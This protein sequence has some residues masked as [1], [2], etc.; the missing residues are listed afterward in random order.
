[1][2]TDAHNSTVL[3]TGGAGFIG[4]AVIRHLLDATS[5]K[6]VNLDA[7]TYAADPDSLSIYSGNARYKF[8]KGDISDRETVARMF[9]EYRPE[10]VIH[11]AAESHVDRSIDDGSTFISTNIVGTYTLLEIARAYW[12]ELTEDRKSEFRF[13]HVSTDEV[14]GSLGTEGY[15]SEKSPYRPNSPYSASKA[16]SDHIARAWYKTYGFPVL[17]SNCSNNFGPS[18]FPEILI[19]LTIINAIQG[20]SIPVY[21]N[22]LNVRDWIYVDDHARALATIIFGG[23]TGE[24]YNIGGG[25]EYQNID[26]VNQ[27]CSILDQ[28]LVNSQ[29][30]PHSDLITFVEDRPGHD[31]RYA[32][33]S[34]KLRNVL[35]LSP[36]ETFKSGLRKTISWY[37]GNQ[38]WW[39]KFS[40][41]GYDGS[42]M[43]SGGKRSDFVITDPKLKQSH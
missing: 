22:G 24:S 29:N 25:N 40:K 34:S 27:I 10:G 30:R 13:L 20:R 3:V 21:G 9:R 39:T 6:V 18:Q 11:L 19:P 38:E 16:A 12:T 2:V 36:A 23:K 26:L 8:E 35:G 7:L 28:E 4:S 5:V 1:M 32:I 41:H 37:I 31:L 42:W 43:Q 33:D 17:V 14:F 15:F